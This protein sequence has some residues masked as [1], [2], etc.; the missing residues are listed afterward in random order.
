MKP[1]SEVLRFENYASSHPMGGPVS[2]FE[3]HFYKQYLQGFSGNIL[4]IG[5]GDGKYVQHL[6]KECP[7]S[8]VLPCD[9]SFKR[10]KRVYDNGYTGVVGSAEELPIRD[11]SFDRVFLMQVIEHV[12]RTSKVIAECKRVLKPGGHCFVL[13]PNYPVKRA[14]DWLEMLRRGK[15]S[16]FFDD[17]THCSKFSSSKLNR[18]LKEHFRSVDVFPTFILGE[19]FSF[20]KHWRDRRLSAMLFS[21]KLLAVCSD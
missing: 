7:Q 8:F 18:M 11:Q 16:K 21:H 13:T 14:Y 3:K 4:D 12:P 2:D 20:I 5:C 15:W 10:I 9:I 1:Q 19:K 17:P 6:K